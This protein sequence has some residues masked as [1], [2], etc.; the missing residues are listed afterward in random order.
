MYVY[1]VANLRINMA[2]ANCLIQFKSFK[3]FTSQAIAQLDIASRVS[4]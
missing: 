4:Y 1:K 3:Q 2:F